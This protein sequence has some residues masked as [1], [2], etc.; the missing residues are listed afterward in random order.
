[1]LHK[2][3]DPSF[4]NLLIQEA[5]KARGLYAGELDNWFGPKSEAAYQSFLRHMNGSTVHICTASTFADPADVAAFRK[6]K[7]T[8]KSDKECFNVGD[9][10]IG[11]WGADTTTEEVAMC[12]LHVDHLKERFGDSWKKDANQRLVMVTIKGQEEECIL[13]DICGA[14]DRIDLNPGAAKR[15]GLKPPALV[16]AQWEWV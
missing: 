9:N 6:C 14:R 4:T 8:G 2:E 1:M 16:D 7:A 5:L 13:A 11:F 12:A 10:G 15:F 3:K